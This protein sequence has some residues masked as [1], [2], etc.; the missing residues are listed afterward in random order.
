MKKKKI[1]FIVSVVAIVA[2]FVCILLWNPLVGLKPFKGLEISDIQE[3]TVELISS[4][5]ALSVND[6]ELANIVKALN[7]TVIYQKYTSDEPLAGQDITYI[8]I[9]NDSSKI[10]IKP[11]GNL[12]TIDG[13]RYKAKYEPNKELSIIANNLESGKEG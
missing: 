5:I 10:N 4:G 1:W 2:I 8:I 3:V 12:I 6:D 7:S 13:I 9:K 11:S